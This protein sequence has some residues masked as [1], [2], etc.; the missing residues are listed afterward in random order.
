MPK[1]TVPDL[2]LPEI[3]VCDTYDR[4]CSASS[5]TCQNCDVR[6]VKYGNKDGH[7]YKSSANFGTNKVDIVDFVTN[8]VLH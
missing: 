1:N 4:R 2:L 7:I 6:V 3:A 8:S 5:M